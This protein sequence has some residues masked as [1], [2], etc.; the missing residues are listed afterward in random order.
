MAELREVIIIGAGPSGWTAATYLSR[1]SLSP[2]IFTGDLAGGQLMLTSEVENFPGFPKGILGPELMMAMAEQ[3]KRF[4]AEVVEKKITK[5]DFSSQPFKVWAGEEEFQAKAIVIST[6][7]QA[8]WLNAPGERERIGSGVSSCANCDAAFFKQ[9]SVVVVGGGDSAMEDALTLTKFAAAVTIVHRRS[10]FK[11]SKIMQDRVLTHPK[12]KVIWDS[13][14]A[15][16]KG[17]NRV[18]SVVLRDLKT[19]TTQEI[20]ADGLF[21]AIGHKPSTEIFADQIM[22]DTKGFVV[23][24]LGLDKQS[25]GLANAAIDENGRLPLPMQT[26]VEGVFACGDCV[27]F[28]YKQAITA[29]GL[30]CMAA[31]DVQA[32]LENH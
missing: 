14:V 10:E 1:A 18:Q 23:T 9:K 30:G 4:G 24:R 12:I 15:E 19:Q 25:L 27:D 20:N 26:S 31:L 16:V 17:E 32:W 22:L 13:E 5:V 21:V 3:A 29:A 2:L 8:I 7:A 28:R 11:A 6:G